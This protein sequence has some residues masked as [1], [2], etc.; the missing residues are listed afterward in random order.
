MQVNK[1]DMFFLGMQNELAKFQKANR[2]ENY[3]SNQNSV[4]VSWW[5]YGCQTKGRAEHDSTYG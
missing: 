5:K 4:C 2:E 1:F 3:K